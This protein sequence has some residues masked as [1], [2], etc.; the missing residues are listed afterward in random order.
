MSAHNDMKN[1]FK[2]T[3]LKVILFVVSVLLNILLGFLL[4]SKIGMGNEVINIIGYILI[5]EIFGLNVFVGEVLN[6][7]V[8]QG[9]AL[10]AFPVLWP[11]FL[12]IILIVSN[13]LIILFLHYLIASTISK[14]FIREKNL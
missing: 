14:I 6:I 13:I 3:K 7:P 4:L 5:L 12:G 2:L 10:D 8:T 11:N 9:P 1:F